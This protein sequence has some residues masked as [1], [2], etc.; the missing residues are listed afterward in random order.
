MGLIGWVKQKDKAEVE[1]EIKI[2]TETTIESEPE[3]KTQPD[4]KTE[5]KTE[6]DRV[7]VDFGRTYHGAD[8]RQRVVPGPEEARARRVDAGVVAPAR[9]PVRLLAVR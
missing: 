8:A 9:R 1:T 5:A 7:F 2:E 3:T 6:T 4:T